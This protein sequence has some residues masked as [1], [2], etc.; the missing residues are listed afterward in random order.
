MTHASATRTSRPAAFITVGGTARQVLET[1]RVLRDYPRYDGRPQVRDLHL[2]TDASEWPDVDRLV[3]AVPDGGEIEARRTHRADLHALM[4]PDHAYRRSRAG[5]A[6]IPE[7][8][9]AG[10]GQYPEIYRRI[11]ALLHGLLGAAGPAPGQIELIRVYIVAWTGRSTGG[12]LLLHVLQV[13]QRL[14]RE[15]AEFGVELDRYLLL[16][17]P[18][19]VNHH[20]HTEMLVRSTAVL[21]ALEAA[22]RYGLEVA[23]GQRLE[24]PV[25]EYAFVLG[26]G[27]GVPSPLPEQL[28]QAAFVLRL[29][30]DPGP[31]GATLR[32]RLWQQEPPPHR[33]EVRIFKSIGLASI[34]LDRQAVIDLLTDLLLAR[35]DALEAAR[36]DGGN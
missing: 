18:T 34:V 21:T 6:S 30:A 11:H 36:M 9:L 27:R 17:R 16:T 25:C 33:E 31:L 35:S 10:A 19:L 32:G 3:V 22:S 26:R 2:D 29:I 7:A 14:K 4:R 1:S 24:A 8:F 15:L 23:E 5:A 20:R 13:G 12:G 28:A